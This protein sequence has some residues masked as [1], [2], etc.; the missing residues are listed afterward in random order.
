[1]KKKYKVKEKWA[2]PHD[3]S[4]YDVVKGSK[5][6]A[7]FAFKEDAEEYAMNKNNEK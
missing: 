2:F 3:F 5:W 4:I 7:S 6:Y 1:M